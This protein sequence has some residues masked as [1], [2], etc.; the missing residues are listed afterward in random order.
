M[1]SSLAVLDTTYPD[2]VIERGEA[3]RYG[4]D[5]V[6]LRGRHDSSALPDHCEGV[7]VQYTRIDGAFLD[8]NPVVRVVG[9]YGV[10]LD[11]VDLAAA[12][13]RGVTVRNVP[14]YC[15]D[16]VATHASA[17]ALASVRRVRE[18]DSLVRS[19]QW[20][21]WNTLR[22]IS[23]LTELRLGIVG[24]GRIGL[25]TARL[26]GPFFG[27]VIGYDPREESVETTTAVHRTSLG[28]LLATSDV[29]SLHCP[30]TPET[31]H[32]ID[33]TALRSMK[34]GAHLVNVSRGGLIDGGAVALALHRGD[35][36]GFAT[37]VLEI[38]P[39]ALSDPLL[40][41]PRTI[42]TNHLAWYSETS[43]KRLR[44]TLAARCAADLAGVPVH[45][46]SSPHEEGI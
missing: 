20:D 5:V 13:A 27:E 23:A 3:A 10:G 25:R 18:A 31:H 30:L 17:L 9:R 40:Q 36:A 42:I 45:C 33:G 24:L 22:P 46:P 41:A 7:L 15:T 38:E 28:E 11:T 21:S 26:L 35:L 16:E 44:S 2:V 14:D 39:P 43:E 12:T 37:D 4:I 32:L 6:D 29:I 1:T 34:R 8:R 19:N